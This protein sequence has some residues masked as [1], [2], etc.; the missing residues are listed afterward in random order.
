[1]HELRAFLKSGDWAAWD[2]TETDQRRGLPPPPLEKPAPAGAPRVALVPPERFSVGA[3]P[4]MQAIGQRRSRRK[5]S[6]DALSLEE[7]SFM[8][9]ATQGV[10][11]IVNLGRNTLRTVPSAGARHPF[12]TYLLANRVAGLTQALYRYLPLEHELCL[13]KAEEGLAAALDAACLE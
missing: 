1:M 8:L 6:D 7:L 9:W 2:V 10:Q 12:E 3:M 13:L 5:Y 4:L 11:K